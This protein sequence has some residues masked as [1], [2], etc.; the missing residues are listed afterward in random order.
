PGGFSPPGARDTAGPDAGS[1]SL[2]RGLEGLNNQIV[3]MRLLDTVRRGVR[4]LMGGELPL[5]VRRRLRA[6]ARGLGTVSDVMA[7]RALW[8]GDAFWSD[9]LH[10]LDELK[11]GH[12][13]FYGW[14]A[15]PSHQ[16]TLLLTPAR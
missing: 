7:T 5:E 16:T 3:E 9:Y 14:V 11:I 12:T 1:E 4:G 6:D 15:N 13:F 8:K 2:P 10:R